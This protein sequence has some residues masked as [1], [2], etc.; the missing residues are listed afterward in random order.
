MSRARRAM[1]VAIVAVLA[2]G[3]WWFIGRNSGGAGLSARAAQFVVRWRGGYQGTMTLPARL[4]WCPG[5]R[6][7]ILEALSGDSAA[8]VVL[9]ER[10]SLTGGAHTV[11]SPDL[12]G[13]IQAPGATM[14]LRWMRF[15]RDSGVTGFRSQG[16]TV[17]IHFANGLASGD[18]NV[19]GQVVQVV[20]RSD[21]LMV[22]GVFR[23]VPVVTTAAGCS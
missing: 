3:G 19:R 9:Y 14:V 2:T 7:G 8:A 12:A 20:P 11:V 4:N 21:T 10:D 23:D 15:G 6:R 1:V 5:T 22:Q 13:S 16:G 18:V 17:R